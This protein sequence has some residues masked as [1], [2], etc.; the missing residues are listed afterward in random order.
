[1]KSYSFI[2]L[3]FF[4]ASLFALNEKSIIHGTAVTSDGLWRCGTGPHDGAKL[5]QYL[6]VL[7]DGNHAAGAVVAEEKS[8]NSF[9]LALEHHLHQHLPECSRLCLFLRIEHSRCHDQHRVDG[10]SWKRHRF[11]PVWSNA[12]ARKKPEKQVHR[13]CLG[14]TRYAVSLYRLSLT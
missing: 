14:A 3:L 10:A 12:S 2:F 9:P 11:F 13:S 8:D 4:S 6:P 5:V 7:H 1:M